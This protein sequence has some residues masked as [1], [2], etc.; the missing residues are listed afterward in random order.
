MSEARAVLW[1]MDGTLI[2]SEDFH[3]ISWRDTMAKE[4]ILITREQF[5]ASFGQRNDS[6]VPRWLGAA[7]TPE[8]VGGYQPLKK[9]SIE[10]SFAKMACR[11]CPGSRIGFAGFMKRDGYRQLLPRRHGPI[12]KWSSKRWGQSTIFRRSSRLKMYAK[13]NRIRKY[14]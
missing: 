6:I 9:S 1:D 3:W 2:D 5:L 11:H 10:T 4:S 7:S 12:L 14:T 8:R 13:E